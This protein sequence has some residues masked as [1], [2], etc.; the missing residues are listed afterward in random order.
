M[1]KWITILLVVVVAYVV[2]HRTGMKN[3]FTK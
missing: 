3:P 1:N 2:W